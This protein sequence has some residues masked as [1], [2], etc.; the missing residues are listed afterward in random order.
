V[1]QKKRCPKAPLFSFDLRVGDV[2]YLEVRGMS[3]EE[4]RGDRRG[5][6]RL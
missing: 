2:I 3:F 5:A 1:G 4:S 6:G